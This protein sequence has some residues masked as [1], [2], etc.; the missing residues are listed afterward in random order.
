MLVSVSWRN[1][2][3][4]KL[5]S[6]VIIVAIAIGVLA[7][8]FSMG[9]TVGMIDQRINSAIRTE[10]SNLQLHHPEYMATNELQHYINDINQIK[11]SIQHRPDVLASSSRVIVQAMIM[12][13]ETGS[14]IKLMGI[15]PEDESQV[16]NIHEKI[17]DGSYF[18]SGARSDP[19][20]IGEALAE[21]LNV[22][23]RSKV[24]ITLTDNEGTLMRAAFRVVGIFRTSNTAYDEM[25][26]FVRAEDLHQYLSI[27]SNAGHEI[28][29]YL[30]E[31]ELTN[32]MKK[33]LSKAYPD[34]EVLTWGEIM[35]DLGYINESMSTYMYLFMGII[36]FALLFG[37]INTML[38]VILERVKELGMLMAVGMNRLRVFGMVVLETIFLSLTGGIIGVVLGVALTYY[39]GDVGIDLSQYS[40]GLE[41]FGYDARIYTSI[42]PNQVVVVTLLVII[43][44][45]VAAL[46]PAYRALKLRP[47]EALRTE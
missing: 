1:I 33:I 27:S 46:Y 7:G 30:T 4:N 14:G 47:A 16:T 13:A 28:A 23:V 25:N 12:S 2:W 10:V 22:D 26:A 31:N 35:P 42:E 17:I 32:P 36:L 29:V 37:I 18:D 40:Q 8:V 15:H 6:T 43:T 39:V 38:M 41:S 5:R 9:F 11:D 24:R 34:L 19:I 21:K 20:V 44:G 45:F 3:R